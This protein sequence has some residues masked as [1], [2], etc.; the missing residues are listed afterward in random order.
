[1]SRRVPLLAAALATLL[2]AAAAAHGVRVGHLHIDHPY[3]LPATATATATAAST[4]PG[5]SR[6]AV[7]FRA[8][9]NRGTTV[10]RLVGAHSTRAAEVRWPRGPVVLPPSQSLRLRHDGPAPIEL[11]DPVPPLRDGERLT[12]T[13]VFEQAGAVDVIVWVQNP[14]S[15]R[16]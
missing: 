5:Q 3:A 12:L 4:S 9:H 10:D 8:L 13:L 11:V 14:R 16:P 6:S 15:H 2:P 1:M 7:Y